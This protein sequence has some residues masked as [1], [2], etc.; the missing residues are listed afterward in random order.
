M[1]AWRR[2][3]ATAWTRL[4]AS[5]FWIARLVSDFTVSALSPIRRATSSVW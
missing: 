4:S 5:S 2:A 3:F 1:I